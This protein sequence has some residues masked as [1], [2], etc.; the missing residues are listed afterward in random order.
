M[1]YN[2]H[3]DLWSDFLKYAENLNGNWL[4]SQEI[5]RGSIVPK[6]EKNPKMFV[7]LVDAMVKSSGKQIEAKESYFESIKTI[8]DFSIGKK[9]KAEL[10]S[11][12]T[13]LLNSGLN[14]P[15]YAQSALS[16][17]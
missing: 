17:T 5:F 2:E 15:K 6:A 13:G 11:A 1:V 14:E 10:T 4:A 7:K 16:L 3:L 12:I 8:S 9:T